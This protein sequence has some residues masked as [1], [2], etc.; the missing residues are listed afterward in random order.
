MLFFFNSDYLKKTF[1]LNWKKAESVDHFDL[2]V[3]D[4]LCIFAISYSFVSC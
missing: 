2:E 3:I 1:R 4:V